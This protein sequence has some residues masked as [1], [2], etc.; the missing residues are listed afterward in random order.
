CSAGWLSLDITE[1]GGWPRFLTFR[2]SPAQSVAPAFAFFAKSGSR[3]CRRQVG[4]ITCPQRNQIAHAASPPTLARNARTGHPQWERCTR[5][6]LK[7]CHPPIRFKGG[8]APTIREEERIS[9]NA[10]NRA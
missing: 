9:E 6:S 1:S 5:R 3:K 2:A 4:L 8:P 10:G 7:V